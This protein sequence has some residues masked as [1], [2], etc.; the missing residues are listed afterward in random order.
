MI[1]I[2]LFVAGAVVGTFLGY[3]WGKQD[4]PLDDPGTQAPPQ[5]GG[6]P[7]PEK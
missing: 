4:A 5:G 3:R 6:G 7:V 2:L 1:E